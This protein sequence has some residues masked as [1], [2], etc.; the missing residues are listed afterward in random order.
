MS[1]ADDSCRIDVWLWR[2]RFFKTRNLAA[3]M[4]AQGCV[5]LSRGG[6]RIRLDKPGHNVRCGDGLVIVLG[7]RQIALRVEALGARRGPAPEA[8][9]LYCVMDDS[10]RGAVGGD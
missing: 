10:A 2:A 8:K 4:V 6:A 3:R 1:E 5:R 9:A 7:E